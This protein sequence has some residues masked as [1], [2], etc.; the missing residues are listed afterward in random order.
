MAILFPCL[1][2]S[3]ILQENLTIVDFMPSLSTDQK[4]RRAKQK[5]C[6]IARNMIIFNYPNTY[7]VPI[8]HF[9]HD[10][11]PSSRT[12]ARST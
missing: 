8:S 9:L 11:H 7:E 1:S 6:S 3:G 5:F 4:S 12:S 2:E 10:F